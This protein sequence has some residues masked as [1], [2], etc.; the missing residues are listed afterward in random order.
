[1]N[2]IP[3]PWTHLGLD[4]VY[5]GLDSPLLKLKVLIPLWTQTPFQFRLV[6]SIFFFSSP[7]QR[8]PIT[9]TLS[10]YPILPPIGLLL[11]RPY[12]FIPGQITLPNLFPIKLLP[13]QSYP[14]TLPA[15]LTRSGNT[16]LHS[17]TYPALPNHLTRPGTLQLASPKN[18]LIILPP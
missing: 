16:S 7:G 12:T 1:L 10:T 8:T 5:P 17:T 18:F 14:A 6:S 4:L 15:F 2:Q 11:I 3:H 9:S 13:T